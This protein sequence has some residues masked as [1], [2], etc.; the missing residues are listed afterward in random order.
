MPHRS[1]KAPI[2]CPRQLQRRS[3]LLLH[4][5]PAGDEGELGYQL[6][7]VNGNQAYEHARIDEEIFQKLHHSSVVLADIT[8]MRPNCFIEL[9]YALGRCLPTE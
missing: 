5:C 9:G 4:R 7:V 6:I 2:A 8:G 1:R 3:E